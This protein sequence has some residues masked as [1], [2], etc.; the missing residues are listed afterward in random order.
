[1]LSRARRIAISNSSFS[2]WAA[3]LGE[4]EQIIAPDRHFWF[5]ATAR[6]NPLKD[7]SDLYPEHFD[8]LIL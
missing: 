4:N 7:T 6:V 3:Y 2:W 5:N 1:M 8:E